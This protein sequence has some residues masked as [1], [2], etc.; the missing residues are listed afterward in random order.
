MA[1]Q[2]SFFKAETKTV[3]LKDHDN[4]KNRV[5]NES[6]TFRG[7]MEATLPMSKDCGRTGTTF[8]YQSTRL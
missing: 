6:R 8:A 4:L 5:T 2:I 3:Y 7:Q 1:K